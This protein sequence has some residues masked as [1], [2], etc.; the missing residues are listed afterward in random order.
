MPPKKKTED[1]AGTAAVTGPQSVGLTENDL[2]LLDSIFK[3]CSTDTKP[4]PSIS[5]D[6]VA[7]QLGLKSAKVVT[8]RYRQ[9]CNKVG[10]FVGEPTAATP[11][12]KKAPASRKKVAAAEAEVDDDTTETPTKKRKVTKKATKPKADK[13]PKVKDEVDDME[14]DLDDGEA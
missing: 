1:G 14:E 3:N 2:K 6:E 9:I 10:W 8:D 13:D 7:Q 4:K 12:P 5:L 11:G